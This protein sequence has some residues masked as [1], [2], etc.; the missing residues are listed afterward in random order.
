MKHER[1][2]TQGAG[3][4]HLTRSVLAVALCL[5]G[6]G[7]ALA[8]IDQVSPRDQSAGL[9]VHSPNLFWQQEV[10]VGI[11]GKLRA[12][13]LSYFLPNAGQEQDFS[14]SVY[15]GA[16]WH[17]AGALT[18]FLVSPTYGDFTIDLSA[19]DLNFT[20]GETLVFGIKGLGPVG[21]CCALVGNG[22]LYAQGRL[23]LGGGEF[24]GVDIGFTTHV[25][26]RGGVVPE[27][28]SL[29]LM[30][31]ALGVAGGVGRLRRA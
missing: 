22:G 10:R 7:T 25:Q 6:P 17:D 16:G 11:T 26:D 12:V 20:A 4:R 8:A 2:H 3:P 28:N 30:A 9:N 18:S 23:F 15:R 14:F 5:A 21:L 29:A 27:P 19:Y 13:D 1:K 31:L 24:E